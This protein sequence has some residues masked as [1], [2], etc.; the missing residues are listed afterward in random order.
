MTVLS[1]W[2]GFSLKWRS[3]LLCRKKVTSIGPPQA[4]SPDMT[5][6]SKQTLP[7]QTP[8]KASHADL[9]HTALN[10]FK[11]ALQTLSTISSN[12]P[13]AQSLSGV[14]EPILVVMTRIQQT[15]ANAQGFVELAARIKLLTPIIYEMG[16]QPS[17]IPTDIA[18]TSSDSPA[19][20]DAPSRGQFVLEAL[21]QEFESI[22]ADLQV[23]KSRGTL[24]RFFNSADNAACL[25][26]HSMNLTQIISIATL[27][28]VD[29]VFQ[30]IKA[31]E[32]KLGHDNEAQ[33]EMEDITGKDSFQ[34]RT[35]VNLDL[36]GI[37]G[38]G[39]YGN[40]GGEGGEGAGPRLELDFKE[41]LKIRKVSGGTGGDGGAGLQVG[42]K[43]GAGKGPV[44][45]VQRR[46]SV[47]PLPEQ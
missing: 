26:K 5:H 7:Q 27:V 43:G 40:I 31:L 46:N 19:G 24:E 20:L 9:P 28:G 15:S 42:G 25:A 29:E 8:G 1:R 11:F 30:S 14:I 2:K 33:I 32:V 36:G 47:Q 37:G 13:L 21:R 44:I 6:E 35:E 22:A 4:S 18:N 10:V 41:R 23:A 17:S 3:K 38:T 16:T 45:G 12:I 34:P 39:G